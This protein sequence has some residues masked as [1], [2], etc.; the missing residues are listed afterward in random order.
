MIEP[1]IPELN[2]LDK[3]LT[4]LKHTLS[5]R[6]LLG[7]LTQLLP[8]VPEAVHQVSHRHVGWFVVY[9]LEHEDVL[10]A[11]PP[12][13]L[14]GR[15][16]DDPPFEKHVA[17]SLDSRNVDSLSDLTGCLSAVQLRKVDR[18]GRLEFDALP[19]VSLDR[20]VAEIVSDRLKPTVLRKEASF[21]QFNPGKSGF[22]HTLLQPVIQDNRV[23]GRR[24]A[25]PLS[26]VHRSFLLGE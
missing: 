5:R 8:R 24:L 20:R 1:L 25:H 17:D 21:A 23:S 12:I 18:V 22:H 6:E 13:P 3:S 2:P 26:G 4:P 7:E 11:S 16:A 15:L 14:A 10:I 9:L 19:A